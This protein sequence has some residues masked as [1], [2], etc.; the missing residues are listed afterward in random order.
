M[1]VIFRKGIGGIDS[2]TDRLE[3]TCKAVYQLSEGVYVCL[4]ASGE[5]YSLIL[6]KEKKSIHMDKMSSAPRAEGYHNLVEGS[7]DRIEVLFEGV[8]KWF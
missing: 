6:N 1:K 4:F 5:W 3:L 2:W 7:A 8:I